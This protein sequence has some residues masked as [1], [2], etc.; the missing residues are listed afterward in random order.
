MNPVFI[1]GCSRSGTTLLGSM[2]GAHPLAIT[3]PESP[4]KIHPLIVRYRHQGYQLTHKDIELLVDDWFLAI[5]RLSLD[6]HRLMAEIDPP[7]PHAVVAWLVAAY[8]EQQGK[9]RFE[10]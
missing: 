5:W 10:T 4:F 2:L 7:T 3:T 6:P 8:A 1:G 9:P